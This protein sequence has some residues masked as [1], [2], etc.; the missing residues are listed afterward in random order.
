MGLVRI[1]TRRSTA[2]WLTPAMLALAWIVFH[3]RYTGT[4]AVAWSDR[5]MAVRDVAQPLWPLIGG[6]A[7]WMAARQR[8]R[9][10][11][12]LVST[13]PYPAWWRE[14]TTWVGTV[15][16]G[17]LAYLLVASVILLAT[18]T[19]ATWGGPSLG[20]IAVGLLALVA[21]GALGYTVGYFLPSRFTPPL[22]AIVLFVTVE[23]VYNNHRWYSFLV[24]PAHGQITVWGITPDLSGPQ[25][26][27]L[28]GVTAL[29]LGS[30]GLVG[31]RPL[32]P[33]IVL[34]AGAL[35]TSA[36]VVLIQ[37][38]VPRDSFSQPMALSEF[39]LSHIT[40]ACSHTPVSVCVHPAFSAQ[41]PRLA[42]TI[43]RIAAPVAGLPGAPTLFLDDDIVAVVN[44]PI[45]GYPSSAAQEAQLRRDGIAVF[46]APPPRTV[47]L[48]P[49]DS[50]S[51]FAIALTFSYS[52]KAPPTA[53]QEAIALW[54]VRRAGFRPDLATPNDLFDQS[55]YAGADA[56]ARRFGALPAATQRAWLHTHY[57]ALRNGEL[58]V[59]DLP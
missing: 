33:G 42:R 29:A 15:T 28:L 50:P 9:G 3:Q 12:E 1:E 39:P 58:S 14:A 36:G 2:L 18:W 13:T 17:V 53:A 57:S 21:S 27:F 31:W 30:L 54:L 19:Q 46:S 26:L 41:L 37:R 48:D 25:A 20:P 5:S 44:G 10:M 8:R 32:V 34:L 45:L 59:G 35:L 52:V 22:V 40:P 4:F 51:Q 38:N 56:A 47:I 49:S 23:M 43:N 11:A 55:W 24:P 6:A 7:A 16:W